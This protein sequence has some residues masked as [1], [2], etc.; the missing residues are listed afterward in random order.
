MDLGTPW[1]WITVKMD[2]ALNFSAV[3]SIACLP[4]EQ[5][6]L[7]CQFL[8]DYIPEFLQLLAFIGTVFLSQPKIN[9]RCI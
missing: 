3:K 5:A 7:Q 6:E 8:T 1:P 4:Q 9:D 2:T